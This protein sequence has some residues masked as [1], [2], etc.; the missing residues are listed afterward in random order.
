V[1]CTDQKARK[2]ERSRFLGLA[3]AALA[4]APRC[5][6]AQSAPSASPFI[7]SPA[8]N[9]RGAGAL[10]LSGGGARGA[11]EAGVIEGLRRAAHVSDGQPLPGIDVVCGASIG[12][13]NG[14]YVATGQYA[15][16]AELWH[17][18]GSQN[19]FQVKRRFA[20]T[21]KPGAF[22]V[23]KIVQ[24]LSLAQGLTKTTQGILDGEAVQNWI[25]AHV[26]PAV[27][28]VLPF[29]F[30]T[31]NLDRSRAELFY[32]IPFVASPAVREAAVDR[33]HAAAGSNVSV[34]PATDA[35]LRLALRA[36]TSIPV[37]FDPV[38]LP[39]DDGAHDRF[40]DGGIADNAPIDVARALARSVYTVLVDP[41]DAA[42]QP[43]DNALEI[44]V[45]SFGVTQQRVFEES[46]RAAAI[47]TQGKRLMESS[48][49]TPEQRR[50]LDSILDADLYSIRPQSELPVGPVEFDRQAKIDATYQ[51]GID[52]IAR[53]WVPI[54]APPL[55]N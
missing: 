52:D 38:I 3:S 46:L 28:V 17:T 22:I 31:T 25:D 23:V 49:T 43:Y 26:D 21:T 55:T 35:V 40:V 5:T 12:S 30:N 39:E 47:E 54:V 51:R 13:L 4:L 33:I 9:A 20:A 41:V 53:G 1:R 27:P 10:V 24:A 8:P 7:A 50:F 45:G 48:A 44:A 19:V 2:V 42:R 15:K 37:L 18:V 16:L 34:R 6:A 36:S 14:W 32:R 11:Y 29:V